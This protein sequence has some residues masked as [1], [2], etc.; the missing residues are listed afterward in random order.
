MFR[1][2]CVYSR[3]HWIVFRPGRL[4]SKPLDFLFVLLRLSGS[5]GCYNYGG[6]G[7]VD[8]SGCQLVPEWCHTTSGRIRGR[9]IAGV[10]SGSGFG[11]RFVQ[12]WRL[13]LSLHINRHHFNNFL[14][15]GSVDNSR[16]QNWW[17]S[18]Y[19]TFHTNPRSRFKTKIAFWYLTTSALLFNPKAI[20][21]Q[22][23]LFFSSMSVALIFVLLSSLLLQKLNKNESTASAIVLM[24]G[25]IVMLI[26]PV[27]SYFIGKD[28][29]SVPRI[30]A[31]VLNF[32]GSIVLFLFVWTD[33]FTN[34]ASIGTA[35]ALVYV[36]CVL[37][38]LTATSDL[39][40][41]V[42]EVEERQKAA[43]SKSVPL[44][45]LSLVCMSGRAFGSFGTGL[46]AHLFSHFFTLSI[47]AVWAFLGF[48]SALITTW[49]FH[50]R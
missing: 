45:F 21:T 30:V 26:T 37:S 42:K 47:S 32:T 34:L 16:L 41:V 10:L 7:D 40:K 20:L 46:L 5:S 6:M 50:Y 14:F 1:H 29:V 2:K 17:K 36:S 33:S 3:R 31:P 12:F 18:F 22:T 9:S 44:A 43:F 27:C 13:P 11:G 8:G 4:D 15:S 28:F 39:Y 38:M 49:N 25:S 19:R 35:V 48:A 24:S 23:P